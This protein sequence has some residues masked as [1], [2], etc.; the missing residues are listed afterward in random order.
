MVVKAGGSGEELFLELLLLVE[1]GLG[2][3]AG[4]LMPE[5]LVVRL[6]V[7]AGGGLFASLCETKIRSR[8]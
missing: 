3:A 8:S 7:V 5:G 1:L 6:L 4:F 2:D